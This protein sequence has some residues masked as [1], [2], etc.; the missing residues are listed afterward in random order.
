MIIETVANVEVPQYATCYCPLKGASAF[1]T[2]CVECGFNK[3]LFVFD[4][5]AEA[6]D[7]RYRLACA[8]PIPRKITT[9]VG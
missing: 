3:G 2:G 8:A 4:E 5:D 6:F 9:I 1:M 7:N